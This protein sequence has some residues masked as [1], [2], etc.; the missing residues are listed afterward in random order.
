[1]VDR[2]G[3]EPPMEPKLV[4][5]KGPTVRRYRNR[6]ESGATG[7]TRTLDIQLGKLVLYQLSYYRAAP[8]R[9]EL[10]QRDR[11]A[12][13][14]PLFYGAKRVS[15]TFPEEPDFTGLNWSRLPESNRGLRLDSGV[16]RLGAT[17][18]AASSFC[19]TT[20]RRHEIGAG[21]GA[22]DLCCSTTWRARRAPGLCSL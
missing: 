21:L 15:G 17:Q 14:L 11:K 8:R 7:G 20:R 10:R 2:K 9:I 16:L 12:R 4:G 1:M 18:L 5:L 22:K 3:L 13:E 6:S 19:G